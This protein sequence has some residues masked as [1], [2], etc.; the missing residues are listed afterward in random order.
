MLHSKIYVFRLWKL[1]KA[2]FKNW[3]KTKQK[4]IVRKKRKVGN[5]FFLTSYP[6][7]NQQINSDKLFLL[8]NENIL[9]KD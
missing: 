1:Y 8:S 7:V 4:H 6:F 2:R 9:H 5:D 3:S